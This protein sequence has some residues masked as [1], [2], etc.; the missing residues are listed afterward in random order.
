MKVRAVFPQFDL[1]RNK[2]PKLSFP[3]TLYKHTDTRFNSNTCP[4]NDPRVFLKSPQTKPISGHWRV[5]QFK[6]V[7][8]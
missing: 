8:S 6:T 4:L 5:Q 1:P 3:E 2:P 7:Y